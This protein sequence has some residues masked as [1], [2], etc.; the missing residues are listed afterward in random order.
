MFA[1]AGAIWGRSMGPA[2]TIAGGGS[3]SVLQGL[4]FDV[5]VGVGGKAPDPGDFLVHVVERGAVG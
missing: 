4:V 1:R 2:L 5:L 3:V